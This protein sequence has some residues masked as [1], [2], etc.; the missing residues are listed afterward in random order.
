M[1]TSINYST[2]KSGTMIGKNRSYSLLRILDKMLDKK[3]AKKQK[4]Q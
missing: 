1:Q 2:Y 3:E 4:T